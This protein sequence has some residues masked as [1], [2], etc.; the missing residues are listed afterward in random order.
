MEEAESTSENARRKPAR[1]VGPATQTPATGAGNAATEGAVGSGGGWYVIEVAAQ[2][3]GV[4]AQT[5]RHYERLGLIA[6]A[7]KGTRPRSPRLYS[8]HDIE[9]VVHIRRLMGDLG[10]NLA[11]VETILHMRDR[12]EALRREMADELAL[13]RRQHEAEMR[14]LQAIIEQLKR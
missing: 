1:N 12:M 14:Q 10:V 8:D 3:A 6:P 2:R 11:G 13:V 5:L 4:H 9:R 7:R